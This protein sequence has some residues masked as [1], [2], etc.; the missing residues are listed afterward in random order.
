[1]KKILYAIIPVMLLFSVFCI[2]PKAEAPGD[3]MDYNHRAGRQVMEDY[4]SGKYG[5]EVYYLADLS[6][7]GMF[8]NDFAV[9]KR[10]GIPVAMWYG[11]DERCRERE[12]TDQEY[13]EFVSSIQKINADSLPDWNTN[14]VL[15]GSENEYIHISRSAKADVYMNNPWHDGSNQIY[16]LL[17]QR[18]EDLFETGDA[19]LY[20][21]IDGAELLID[22]ENYWVESVY[23][24]GDD[25][26]VLVMNKEDPTY[27][28][29]EWHSFKNNTVGE[30][31]DEPE[32][33]T[34]VNAWDDIPEDVMFD[35]HLNNYP[36]QTAWGEYTV[37]A[38]RRR[39]DHRIFYGL[40]LVRGNEALKLVAEGNYNK[41]VV[42]PGT[43]LVICEEAENGWD[44]PRKLVKIN[45]KTFEKTDID[46]PVAQA[47]SPRLCL[48]GKLLIA[49]MP[50]NG[51]F[52]CYMYD[53]ANDTIEPV[54]GDFGCLS[55]LNG[56]APQQMSLPNKYY[57]LDDQNT[58]G[59]FDAE[60]YRFTELAKVPVTIYDNDH[61]WVDE[62]EHKIYIVVNGDLISLPIEVDLSEKNDEISVLLDGE[63]LAFDSA[64][65]IEHDRTLVPFRKILEALG[66]EVSWNGDEQAVLAQK[67]G[68]SLRLQIDSNQISVNGEIRYLDAA[69]RLINSST[70]VPLRFISE[71]SG[72]SVL[73]SGEDR[74][75][76]INSK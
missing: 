58:V 61:M 11:A 50:V 62:Q 1:M 30:L 7:G 63:K 35:E 49:C 69:P 53:A 23:K 57:V 33:F 4:N 24:N 10:N 55:L 51:E 12:L 42:I 6:W 17:I 70:Y 21:D 52:G 28:K 46:F 5:D 75:V 31:V 16:N 41:P 36:W 37:K 2:A 19:K 18:F 73:W 47:V 3:S 40:F 72:C 67:Q 25:F 76:L 66:Y 74:T 44:N 43:D 34:I 68:I 64:P 65:I 15:D 27:N 38:L 60:T 22:R 39:I 71:V 14:R 9:F 8:E 54:E 26:R 13:N 59:I 48:D 56:R 20:Y 29:M 45:L 32:G